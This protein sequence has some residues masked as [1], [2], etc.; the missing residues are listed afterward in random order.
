M[1]ITEVA[2]CTREQVQR[3]LNLADTP[4]LAARVDSAIMSGARQVH[5]LL[6]RVFYPKTQTLLFDQP[7]SGTLWLDDYG[8]ELSAAPTQILSGSQTMTVG[9][10]VLLRPISGPP[11]RWLEAS[12][13]GTVFWQS[14]NT[15]QGAVSITADFGYP[16][17]PIVAG[18]L[19]ST[20][21]SAS[22][23]I[24]LSDSSTVGVGSLILIDSER[25]LVSDKTMLAT[26]ATITADPTSSK[27]AV[28]LAVS[29]GA[30]INPGELI[31][32]DA[33][34]M[35]VEYVVGNNLT[36]RRAVNGSALA[37]HTIGAGV[38]APRTAGVLRAR[39][40]T[41]AASHNSGAT[42]T[43]LDAPS[44]VSELNLGYAITNNEAALAAYSRTASPDTT[45][46]YRDRGRGVTDL[47]K[48]VVQA[49]GRQMR[50]RAV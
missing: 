43:R 14:V 18:T 44:L 34:R 4:E 48:D 25:L 10:D 33:E 20:P 36:V 32:V 42:I 9:T 45:S 2:Y 24:T 11:Y 41:I 46:L 49:Y 13:A 22:A 8:V 26:G 40:G 31:L 6:H 47:A 19:A 50:S 17:N 37:A 7:D 1:A 39:L 35:Q 15:P 3:V 23:T 30:L 38:S 5:G 29:N 27:A 21:T 28:T 12:Y 16:P